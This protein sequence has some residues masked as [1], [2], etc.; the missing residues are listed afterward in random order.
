MTGQ[1][2]F[3]PDQ[4]DARTPVALSAPREERAVTLSVFGLVTGLYAAGVV[5]TLLGE[6]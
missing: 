3:L 4:G 5:L 6:G 1:P 2:S